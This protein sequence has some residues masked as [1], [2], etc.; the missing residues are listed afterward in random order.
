M[1]MFDSL[2]SSYDLGPGFSKELQTKDLDCLCEQ[3]WIDPVGRLYKIDYN[4]TQDWE[5]VPEEERKHSLDVYRTV[6]NGHR[7][8]VYPYI[9]TR[10]IEVYPSKWDA[11][12]SLYPRKKIKFIDGVLVEIEDEKSNNDWKD[13]Y[14]SLKR[15]VKKHYET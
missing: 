6:S 4:G 8:R 15:W 11:Y 2:R 3:Y 1:G 7:G 13:R 5:K 10:E 14:L 9:I 12:Y